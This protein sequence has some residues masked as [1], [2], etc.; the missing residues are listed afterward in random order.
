M[1]NVWK[2]SHNCYSSF[3]IR[4]FE[5]ITIGCPVNLFLI[6]NYIYGL[7]YLIYLIVSIKVGWKVHIS[8]VDDFF[9]N[10]IQALQHE[11]KKLLGHK[12][13]GTM[14]KNK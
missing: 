8:A 7:F 2:Y 11:L 1:K 3:E 12:S 4:K 9:T 5:N 10:G 14:L 13:K 6:I